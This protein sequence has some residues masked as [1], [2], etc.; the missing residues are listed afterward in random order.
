MLDRFR[1]QDPRIANLELIAASREVRVVPDL[2][3]LLA[4]DDSLAPRVARTISNLVQGIDPVQ[5]SSLDEQVRRASYAH[6]RTGAWNRLSPGSVSDLA[7]TA[8]FDP[9]V[10]GLLAS[11]AKGFVRAAALEVLAQR[12]DGQEIPFL[13]LRANDWVEPVASRASELLTGRLRADNR[14]AVLDA[15]PFIVRLLGQRRRDHAQIARAL[16]SVLLS[17]GGDDALARGKR[18][19]APVRQIM[20]ELLTADGTAF[21]KVLVNAALADPDVVIRARSIRS[22]AADPNFDDRI[23][24][25]ER[26][27]AD[28]P[29]PGIRRLVLGLI[30]EH[31][32]ERIAAVFPGVLFDRVASVRALARFVIGARQLPLVPRDLYVQSL[33]GI[34]PKQIV[35]AIEGLGETGTHADADL[36]A[37]FLSSSVPRVRRAALRALAKLDAERAVSSA[38]DA[39]ADAGSSVRSVAVDILATNANR[40][41]FGVVRLVQRSLPDPLVRRSLLRL[42]THAQKWE[43]AALLLEALTDPDDAVRIAAS[44]LVDLW[45]GGFN[46]RQ[47]QPTTEQLLRIHTLMDAV[48]SRLPEETA[49]LL[50][51]SISPR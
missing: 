48:G 4:L 1:R 20:Y 51:F 9:A 18:F 16:R 2:L 17:D 36:V 49:S 14:R 50:R 19:D 8:G 3:R 41:D 28:D 11:H 26:L 24:I 30:A 12:T 25:L 23:A 21:K 27:L 15:L 5:L 44:G 38:I 32:P 34:L 31:V 37:P 40:V 46:R 45:L 39:L 33:T 43:A 42:F 29:V 13:A 6:H 22:L 47:S 7:A 35:G 10:I